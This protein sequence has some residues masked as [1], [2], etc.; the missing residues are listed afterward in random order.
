MA[1]MGHPFA[2]YLSLGV[3]LSRSINLG[4]PMVSLGGDPII[5]G[6]F[7]V[8]HGEAESCLHVVA[9]GFLRPVCGSGGPYPGHVLSYQAAFCLTRRCS[10]GHCASHQSR[11]FPSFPIRIEWGKREGFLPPSLR[12][13]PIS[14]PCPTV[15]PL[16][17]SR[18]RER[19]SILFLH[20]YLI[21]RLFFFFLL[22]KSI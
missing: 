9:L 3:F 5:L 4:S 17:L 15:V 18:G 6:F 11:C 1:Y 10:V 19:A 12:L 21:C 7:Q 14:A 8:L 22:A 2:P 20:L 16:S 13:S